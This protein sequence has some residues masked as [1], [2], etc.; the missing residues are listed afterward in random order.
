MTEWSGQ[1][2]VALFVSQCCVAERAG[3]CK[4][5]REALVAI[6]TGEM[7]VDLLKVAR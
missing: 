4:T 3:V 2:S 1:D 6:R 7:V 5:K